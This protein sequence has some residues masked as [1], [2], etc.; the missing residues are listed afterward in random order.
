MSN[1]DR[2]YQ[3]LPSIYRQRDLAQGS[4]LRELLQVI[5]EQ[6]DVVEADID[7]LYE[8]WFIETC[9]DWVAPYIADLIGYRVAAEAGPPGDSATVQGL[10]LNRVL[11][12][13]REVA[14]TVRYRRRKGTL[15]L[16][17]LLANDVAQ[18]PA[19]AVEF[20]TLL[21]WTQPLNHL[22]PSRGRTVDLRQPNALAQLNGPFDMLAHS[23][24]VAN[25]QAR[26]DPGRYNLPNVGVF[27]WRLKPYSVTQTPAYCLEEAGPHCYTFSVLGNDTPLFTRPE[28]ETDP[29]HTAEPL[30]LPVPISRF[31]FTVPRPDSRTR[32]QASTLYYGR[33][34]S[35][36]IW[37]DGWVKPVAGKP[38]VARDPI[39]ST[40]IIPADLSHWQY[41]PPP[42][43]VAVDPERG[44]IVFPPNQLPKQGVRVYYHYGF[45]DDVGGGEYAR[46]LEQSAG[47]TVYP[48]G[49]GYPYSTINQALAQI[50]EGSANA[51]IEIM[52]SRVYTEP[53]NRI[54]LRPNQSLQ[55][56]AASGARPVIRLLDYQADFP[57]SFNVAGEVGST[58]T[59]DGLLLM[60]RGVR[61]SGDLAHIVVRHCTLVPGWAPD[62]HCEPRRPTE[63]SLELFNVTGDVLIDHSIVG[64]IQVNRDEV[65]TDPINLTLAD[66]ILDATSPKLE[67]IGAPGCPVAHVS[68]RVYRSTV[69]GYSQVHAMPLTENSIFMGKV[70]VARRQ[71]GCVRF[72]YVPPGSKTP[73]RYR[74]QPDLVEAAAPA[75]AKDRERQWVRPRFNSQRYGQHAYCQLAHL[76]ADEIKQGADDGSEM[77]VFHNL[78]EPQRQAILQARLDEFTPADMTAGLIYAT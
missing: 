66:S 40:Q 6:V 19:R 55:I 9:Q 57:D 15:A 5:A 60:G 45:S 37:A 14:N 12:P 25:L 62:S 48:V 36:A 38:V 78:F 20:Y 4:P 61:L 32:E 64:S 7:Q 73:R 44:R 51:I 69:I 50:Q 33:D 52:D 65:Q 28:P 59:L 8:N 11:F 49:Q 23:V 74:C 42:N 29:T 71:T 1:P 46:T 26:R 67:A 53:F 56:R 34:R 47:A 2:L 24:E 35:L 77:G 39:P 31:A 13:R 70:T 75:E 3:L 30:N 43:Y 21:G 76:C 41:R 68:L 27:I 58:L 22:N 18:W 63:P 16:L 17:E 10:A 72:C 54:Q